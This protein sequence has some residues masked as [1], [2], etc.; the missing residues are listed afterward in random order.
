MARRADV[1][2]TIKKDL[3]ID[4]FKSKRDLL[5]MAYLSAAIILLFLFSNFLVLAAR[6]TLPILISK[7]YEGSE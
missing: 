5:S 4:L 3:E 7:T 1:C 6:V 2:T